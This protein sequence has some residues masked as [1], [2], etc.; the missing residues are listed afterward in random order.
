[1]TRQI[2]TSNGDLV[3]LDPEG[4]L[5]D[6]KQWT[7]EVA[8]QLAQ[9]ENIQLGTFHWQVIEYLREFYEQY[10]T[11]PNM[12]VLVKQL[13]VQLARPELNSIMLMTSF[14]ESPVRI[15]CKL[16]GLPKPSNCL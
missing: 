4:Y 14:G 5:S 1:M 7:P 3:H 8:T 9:M 6:L 13:K 16:S 10:E 2:T 12:R 11:N 15:A